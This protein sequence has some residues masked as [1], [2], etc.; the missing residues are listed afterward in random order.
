M[1]L[2]NIGKNQKLL[3]LQKLLVINSPNKLMYTES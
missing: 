1:G 3:N 2:F